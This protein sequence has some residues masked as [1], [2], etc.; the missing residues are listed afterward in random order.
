MPIA[1]QGGKPLSRTLLFAIAF[2]AVAC[3]A[4]AEEPAASEPCPIREF[5]RQIAGEWVGVCKQST[6][7]RAADDKYFRAVITE[8]NS[9][10]FKAEF[11]YFRTGDGGKLTRIGGSSVTTTI[12]SDCQATTRIVGSGEL[13]VDNKPK[14]QEHDLTECLTTTGPSAIA[15]RGS[16]S[17]K[18]LGM[19]LGLGKL[20]KVRDDQS[21]WSLTGGTLSIHQSL[22]IAFRALCFSKGFKLDA[23]YSAVRGSDIASQVPKEETTASKA[24]G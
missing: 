9:G 10:C 7:G 12:S 16:G 5:F 1:I 17:L 6:D 2:V 18:V 13:L 24:G 21:S 23:T 15:A 4:R 14:K 3:P 22:S 19:P 11:E 20:G 8:A